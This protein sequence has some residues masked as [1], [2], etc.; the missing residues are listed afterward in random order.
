MRRYALIPLALAA[1]PLAAQ[2]VDQ[3]LHGAG[4]AADVKAGT[5]A[6]E[7]DH[8]QVTFG[9]SHMGISPFAGTFSGSSGSLTVDPANP[10]ATRLT[11]TIP[12]GSVMTTSA[13]LTQ[14]LKSADWLDAA[15]FPTA[16]FTSTRVSKL[17]ADTVRVEGNLTLHGVTKPAT[18]TAKLFGATNNPMS[19]KPSLG[20]T[21][22]TVI[23]R[24]DFGIGYGVPIVGD[25]VTLT[26]AAAFDQ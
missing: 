10:G 21:G 1:A 8:T 23:K 17:G 6:V 20:F 26:I 2:M 15:K 5:Y 16:T 22:T 9:V 25:Q 13:K 24:S 7:P 11:V 3:P 12:T 18:I 14:E 19:K 4:T